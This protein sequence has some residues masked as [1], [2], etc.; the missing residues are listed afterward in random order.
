MSHFPLSQSDSAFFFFSSPLVNE[1]LIK[2]VFNV[3]NIPAENGRQ[4]LR[5]GVCTGW[6]QSLANQLIERNQT[7]NDTSED[8]ERDSN[9]TPELKVK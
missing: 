2:F 3:I 6:L 7:V 8:F 5:L 9:F 1:N 4:Y